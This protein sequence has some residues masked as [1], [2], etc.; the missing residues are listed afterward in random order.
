MPLPKPYWTAN[1]RKESESSS[2]LDCDFLTEEEIIEIILN[3]ADDFICN[4]NVLSRKSD[5]KL[6]NKF[7]KTCSEID[8][9]FDELLREQLKRSSKNDATAS[10]A[11]SDIEKLKNDLKLANEST[12]QHSVNELGNQLLCHERL[13]LLCESKDLKKIHVKYTLAHDNKLST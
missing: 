10:K 2:E 11:N 12:P 5:Y 1:K 9:W 7:D 4:D 3:D 13:H 6:G 8:D